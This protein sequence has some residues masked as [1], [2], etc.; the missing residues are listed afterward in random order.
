M[1]TP[2]EASPTSTTTTPTPDE[3]FRNRVAEKT[4]SPELQALV[5]AA[6]RFDLAGPQGGTWIVD[7]RPDSAGVR[8]GE[9][10]GQCTFAMSDE[11]FLAMVA[12]QFN[13]RLGFMTGRLKVSGDL[14]LAMKLS[15]AIGVA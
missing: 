4:G 9:E 6:Y 15:Q 1:A 14:T 10:E 12:G 3:L 11:D 8:Q 5:N 2:G 13:P 7:F